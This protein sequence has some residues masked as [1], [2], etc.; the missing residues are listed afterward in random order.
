MDQSSTTAE[1]APLLD[2]RQFRALLGVGERRFEELLAA[3]T[4]DRPLDLGPRTARWHY[5]DYER[6]LQRLKRRAPI[7]QPEH[8]RAL[9][10]GGAS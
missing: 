8:L 4:V 10:K 7:D 9:Q 1:P 6:A 2:R 3:G 5:A